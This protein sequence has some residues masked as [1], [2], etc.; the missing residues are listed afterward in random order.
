MPSQTPASPHVCDSV[1]VAAK[2][3][4]EHGTIPGE[5]DTPHPFVYQC[6]ICLR[7]SAWTIPIE[8]TQVGPDT[9]PGISGH[10]CGFNMTSLLPLSGTIP[11]PYSFVLRFDNDE[12]RPTLRHVPPPKL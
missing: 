10:S 1:R 4:V 8:K 12:R 2:L 9:K 7:C 6:R 5:P 11:A 3:T